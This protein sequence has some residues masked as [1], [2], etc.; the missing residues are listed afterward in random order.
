MQQGTCWWHSRFPSW[1]FQRVLL[2]CIYDSWQK[3]YEHFKR[4]VSLHPTCPTQFCQLGLL[5]SSCKFLYVVFQFLLFVWSPFKEC[6]NLKI[7]VETKEI[8]TRLFQQYTVGYKKYALCHIF[9]G[10]SKNN[11]PF[12]RK[13]I[14]GPI[15]YVARMCRLICAFFVR[16]WHKQ[17]FACHGSYK[18]AKGEFL[19]KTILKSKLPDLQWSSCYV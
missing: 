3:I 5:C 10:M 16:I 17:V 9:C 12:H 13:Y 18:R 7:R 2:Q 15:S 1:W 14:K 19:L 8:V 6:Y 4:I 11:M